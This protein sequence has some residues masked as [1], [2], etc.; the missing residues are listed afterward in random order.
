MNALLQPDILPELSSS[1]LRRFNRQIILP[2]FGIEAQRRLKAGSVLLIGLGGLGSPASL[3]LAAAGVGRIGLVDGD[4]VEETNLQRQIVHGQSAL[5]RLKN[6]SAEARLL[7]INPNV[8][9]ERH[10]VRL[11]IDN[12]LALISQYDVIIDGSDNFPTRYLVNDAC[13]KLGKPDVYGGVLRFDGQLSVFDAR[14][15][16]CYRCMFPEPPPQEFAP[17]C[18]EAGVLGV[19]PGVIG[20]LQATEALKLLSGVGS[21]M[22]GRMLIYD[23]LDLSFNT[24]HIAKDPDCPVCS[25]AP[26]DIALKETVMVCA[27]PVGQSI[28]SGGLQARLQAQDDL[29]IVDVRNPAEWLPGRIP[30]AIGWP[31]PELERA[32]NESGASQLPRD[33]DIVLVCQSGMRSNS[34]IKSLV[35]AGYDPL[36]LYSLEQGMA[37]WPG[38]VQLV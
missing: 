8:Q 6:E 13:V 12:A 2:E 10:D 1:E 22:I 15:G 34:V 28:S 30:G 29:V 27:A 20:S 35:A 38:D 19:L 21:P 26:Q 23:G 37:A 7:D 11:N 32:L 14:T 33:R 4:V 17:N 18:S 31:K 5:G 24:V 36:R 16:P 25:R 3:Y 9:I